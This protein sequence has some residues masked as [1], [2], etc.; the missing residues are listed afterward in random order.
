MKPRLFVGVLPSEFQNLLQSG[1]D[2]L[3]VIS[4]KLYPG[5][6]KLGT[7]QIKLNVLCA[8]R[9]GLW[10][11]EVDLDSMLGVD[12]FEPTLWLFLGYSW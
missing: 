5:L 9:H 11:P 7:I 6:L 2:T 10:L 8:W 4:F 1:P 3:G 12:F